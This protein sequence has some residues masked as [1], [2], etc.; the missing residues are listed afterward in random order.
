MPSDQPE[1]LVGIDLGT[2]Y[3]VIAHFD[4]HGHVKT[5]PNRTGEPRTPSVVYLNGNSARVGEAAKKMAGVE[6]DRVAM[7]VKR[8]MGQRHYCAPIDGRNMRPETLS[9]IILR[10]LKI[11]A[12]KRIG[13]IASAVITVP[14]FFN[15]ARRKATQDAGRIAGLN[16]L[17]I[18][19]EPTAAALA[20][21][22]EGQDQRVGPGRKIDLPSGQLTALVYDLGGG[23]FDVSVVRLALKEFK[24]LASGGHP[25][26]GGKIGTTASWTLLRSS[27]NASSAST[28]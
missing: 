1:N 8:D 26:L 11:D 22:L 15:D 24:T 9:A 2:T 17:D 23:T 27:S 10:K 4:A 18:I 28:H 5:I 21:R 16:V 20:Y 19:N 3:S 7:F 13:P 25:Q 12:E 6:S 14:A